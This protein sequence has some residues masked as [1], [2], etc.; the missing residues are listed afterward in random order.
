MWLAM[1]LGCDKY[2]LCKHFNRANDMICLNCRKENG[3][4]P[5]EV[6]EGG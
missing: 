6:R 1:N 3:F 4:D 2:R 5:K